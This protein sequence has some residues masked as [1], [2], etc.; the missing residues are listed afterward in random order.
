MAQDNYSIVVLGNM[1]PSIHHPLWYQRLELV[2]D[3][4]VTS[5]LDSD[6]TLC[7]PTVSHIAFPEF[8]IKCQRDRWEIN[9]A[10]RENCER[11]SN[12]ASEV[13]QALDHTQ[14][15]AIGIN[16]SL[17]IDTQIDNVP[18]YL[19]TIVESTGLSLP[20]KQEPRTATLQYQVGADERR[21]TIKIE[22]SVLD[23]NKVFVGQNIHYDIEQQGITGYFDF[24]EL[25]RPRFIPDCDEAVELAKRVATSL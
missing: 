3:E 24:A 4:E 19:A 13:F 17:H 18:D 25:L 5:A 1:N 2:N 23:T 16:V 12:I 7:T 22:P 8:S 6:N 20:D 9:T 21:R 15:S 14:L 10:K 11:L